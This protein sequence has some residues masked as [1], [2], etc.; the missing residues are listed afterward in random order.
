MKK[1][2]LGQSISILANVGVIAGILLLAV[3]LQQNNELLGAQARLARV[4]MRV[5]G[6][7]EVFSNPELVRVVAKSRDQAALT[8]EEQLTLSL[9]AN[10]VFVRWQ[11]V[12]GEYRQGLIEEVDIPLN[13]WRATVE[14][15]PFLAATWRNTANISYRPDFVR[16]MEENV[17]NER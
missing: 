16:W 13:E 4:Q 2:D 1:L 14:T 15:L 10:N 17:V 3:E 7:V 11:Y 9:L 12:Y 8:S 6:G 5:D